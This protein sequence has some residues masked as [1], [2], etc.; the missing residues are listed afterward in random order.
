LGGP[1]TGIGTERDAGEARL[2]QLARAEA[3]V[4]DLGRR[5][6]LGADT[7]ELIQAGA[8]TAV[9][10]LDLDLAAVLELA[11]DRD[12]LVVSAV[13][14]FE[15]EVVGT[16]IPGGT[17]SLSG[18]TIVENGPVVV[19]DLEADDRFTPEGL[20]T[21]HGVHSA[22]SVPLRGR[23]RPLGV[24]AGYSL[25]PRSF[26]ED[27]VNL[28]RSAGN[29]LAAAIARARTEDELRDTHNLLH[30]VVEGSSDRVFVKDA[31]GRYLLINTAGAVAVG[32]TPEDVVGR[33]AAEIYEPKTAAALDRNDREVME[34]GEARTFE[35]TIPLDGVDRVFLTVKSP[36]FDREGRL[37]GIIGIARDITARKRAEER[38]RFL[39]QA[40]AVLDTSLDPSKTLQ[41]I[42][43]LA[44][45]GVADLC[46]IDL[47]EDDGALHGVAVAA[48]E[49]RV[50]E[51]LID[52]RAGF[53]IN[54][55]GRHPVAQVLRV[56]QAQV[57]A[58][59][60]SHYNEIAQSDDHLAFARELGYRSAVVAPLTARGRTLGAISLIRYQTVERYTDDDVELAR[61]LG[62]RAAMALDNARLYEHEH[63]VSETLQRSLLPEAFPEFPGL[64]FAARYVPGGPGVD[65]GGD[66]YDVLNLPG[67]RVGLAMGDVAGRGLRAA[68]V[69]GQLRTTVRVCTSGEAS[70]GDAL[71]QIDRLFQRLEPG[72]MATLVLLSA[73]PAT[74]S[75]TYSAAAHP[76]PLVVSPEGEVRYLE[77]GRGLPLGVAPAP[78]FEEARSRLPAGS[79]LLLYT[80]G[81]VERPGE[82]IDESM[83]RLS[84]AAATAPADAALLVNHI[85]DEMLGDAARPDD[86]AMLAV[87]L[88]PVEPELDI[89]L[90]GPRDDLSTL[91]EELRVWLGRQD[92]PAAH[93]EELILACSEAAAN[94]MEHAYGPREGPVR[95]R[96]RREGDRITVSVRDSGSWRAPQESERGRGLG[97]IDAMMDSVE[98]VKGSDGTEVRLVRH[99]SAND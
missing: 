39:A 1:G 81:L 23:P 15:P 62:R 95:V 50:G 91:R 72:E 30:G 11:P 92:V 24:L 61:D 51:R 68:S 75:V 54:P 18:F 36:Y 32:R 42:A 12:G 22:V 98:I 31:G 69:M 56:G 82:N 20:L 41:T 9:G 2:R 43:N 80:D 16:V 26:G 88:A 99:L 89:R 78:R 35:E 5:A 28:M 65:V 17:A 48:L 8:E 70:P 63:D 47:R 77:G 29:I 71:G 59:L 66:W 7:A 53:P 87:H 3:A 37:A 96:G 6:L 84:A 97:V 19:D 55:H 25:E 94:A 14:G 46:V 49:P 74:G 60:E 85:C 21:R 40:S 64:R 86:V 4:A 38:Q 52:L 90:P 93:A 73:D 79:M 67:D 33:T 13:H 34:A 10:M 45:P 27:D 76:P 44:V 83:D 58:E 57:F